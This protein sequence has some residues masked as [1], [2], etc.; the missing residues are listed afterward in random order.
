VFLT[1]AGWHMRH[2][3]SIR[4][5]RFVRKEFKAKAKSFAPES[6]ELI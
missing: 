6:P 3:K 2:F 1:G 5:T 4:R